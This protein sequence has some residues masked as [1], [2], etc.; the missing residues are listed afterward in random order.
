M[1][2]NSRRLDWAE[3]VAQ[4]KKNKNKYFFYLNIKKTDSLGD[5]GVGERVI[6]KLIFKTNRL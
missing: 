4:K 3:C 6:I 5:L 2:S 1:T